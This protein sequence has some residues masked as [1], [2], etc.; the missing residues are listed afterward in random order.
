LTL[1]PHIQPG[2]TKLEQRFPV[3]FGSK[4]LYLST[5]GRGPITAVRVNGKRWEQFDSQ[6]LFLPYA[7][8]PAVATIAIALGGAEPGL[9]P[10]QPPEETLHSAVSEAETPDWLARLDAR[11]A[12]LAAFHARLVQE[13]LSE[14]YEAAHAKLAVDYVAVLHQRAR[15]QSE[16]RLG[17]LAEP[18]QTAADNSYTET[19]QRL[20]DGIEG[21][22]NS[23]GHAEEPVKRWMHQLWMGGAGAPSE[24]SP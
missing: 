8:T 12:R 16:G 7:Q 18:S 21:V 24:R 22:I 20:C 1:I 6:A 10:R 4:K 5:V 19:A 9:S 2:V 3:R 11:A 14:T 17:R 13:G 23:Y 15:L